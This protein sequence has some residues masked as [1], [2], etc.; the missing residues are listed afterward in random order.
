MAFLSQTFNAA[1]QSAISGTICLSFAGRGGKSEI[2]KLL[3]LSACPNTIR[4]L[5]GVSG[6]ADMY[7]YARHL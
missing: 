1:S 3:G 6:T 4:S 7:S 2:Y 5:E